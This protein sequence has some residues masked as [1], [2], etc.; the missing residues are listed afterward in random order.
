MKTIYTNLIVIILIVVAIIIGIYAYPLMSEKMVTHWNA[1]GVA[2]GYSS[3][4]LGLFLLPIILIGC[5]VLF[6]ILP[7]IDPH[8]KIKEFVGYYNIFIV[9]F[10]LFLFYIFML[11]IMFNLYPN[12]GNMYIYLAPAFG[13][14]F[15]YCGILMEKA[16]R[17]WFIG[18]KTPWTL[19]SDYVWNKTHKLGGYLF[20]ICAIFSLIG[21]FF[22]K[23]AI[24]IMLIPIVV[25]TII[26]IIYSYI[27]YKKEKNN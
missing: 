25:S 8:K 4:F 20:K 19:S 13:I 1:N 6:K 24:W 10:S 11:S 18:I 16:K 27:V 23:I 9:I 26:V 21:I 14:L 3:K 15:Y 17:N 5:I 2:D 7:R 22:N 12:M